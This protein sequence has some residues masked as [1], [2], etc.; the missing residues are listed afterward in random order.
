MFAGVGGL[1]EGLLAAAAG[2]K[3]LDLSS[4][5]LS[6]SGVAALAAALARHPAGAA[7]VQHL[8]LADNPAIDD[9]AVCKL[10]ESLTG[11]DDSA[12]AGQDQQQQ[13]Q[14]LLKL[15][16]AHAGVGAGGVA[17][18]SKVLGL[19]QLSL[20]GCKLGGE[21]GEASHAN[22]C[23]SDCHLCAYLHMQICATWEG[24][25]VRMCGRCS[26]GGDGMRHH[27]VVACVSVSFCCS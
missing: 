11:S 8:V 13:Q 27:H 26:A 7:A 14:Q 12:A 22:Q 20:F 21:Q 15:D 9:D 25:K 1:A 18:L 4:N 3:L 16:L 10:A 6:S 2:L 19:T 17:A 24:S 23:I 5:Q